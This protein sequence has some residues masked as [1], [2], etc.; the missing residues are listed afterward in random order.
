MLARAHASQPAHACLLVRMPRSLPVHA[1]SCA[2]LAA[3]PMYVCHG[4]GDSSVLCVT[5]AP[6]AAAT[7][8]AG[9]TPALRLQT[10]RRNGPSACSCVPYACC[11]LP[12]LSS[13]N[14]MLYS[15]RGLCVCVCVCVCVRACV[16]VRVCACVS[17]CTHSQA[18]IGTQIFGVRKPWT[19]L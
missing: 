13:C 9:E 17:L 19:P 6:R 14:V 8:D 15:N 11:L 7:S 12:A 2:C 10:L 4:I 1:C 3:C 5:S 16:R 18:H